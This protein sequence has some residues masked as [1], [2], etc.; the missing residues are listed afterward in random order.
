[1]TRAASTT[2]PLSLRW[3]A[4]LESPPPG[5]LCKFLPLKESGYGSKLCQIRGTEKISQYF[6]KGLFKSWL[7]EVVCKGR[8]TLKRSVVPRGRATERHAELLLGGGMVHRFGD[9][10]VLVPELHG[11]PTDLLHQRE[12]Q[13]VELSCEEAPRA[14]QGHGLAAGDELRGA[15]PGGAGAPEAAAAGLRVPAPGVGPADELVGPVLALAAA[16]Q[17]H[18]VDELVQKGVGVHVHLAD[19][20]GPR[21]HLER[22]HKPKEGLALHQ[23]FSGVQH[24]HARLAVDLCQ[25]RI[26]KVLRFRS[27]TILANDKG[28][29]HAAVLLRSGSPVADACLPQPGPSNHL[30]V[31]SVHCNGH[32]AKD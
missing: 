30:S 29:V 1:M 28:S 10:D 5:G 6:M 17:L 26:S 18:P 27:R 11:V 2:A 25:L 32:Q 4:K 8:V 23:V 9:H 20:R 7:L 22:G 24:Q 3:T 21:E 16:V 12:R 13:D 15:G 19:V 14:V 31:F